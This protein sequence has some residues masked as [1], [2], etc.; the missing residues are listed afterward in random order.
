MTV[1]EL[2]CLEKINLAAREILAAQEIK[3]HEK[4]QKCPVQTVARNAK[5]LLSQPRAGLYTAETASRNTGNPGSNLI[6][7]FIFCDRFITLFNLRRLR[8]GLSQV[9]TMPVSQTDPAQRRKITDTGKRL[10]HCGWLKIPAPGKTLVSGSCAGRW[11]SS[12]MHQR[13]Q[14]QQPAAGG[15]QEFAMHY[16][17]L[18]S[19]HLQRGETQWYWEL[20][21]GAEKNL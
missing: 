14:L 3:A 10:P 16:S 4:W 13:D 18:F 17:L 2:T 15:S 8:V 1:W 7:F 6:I 19:C 20:R 11:A 9:L 12:H 21:T 5:Y